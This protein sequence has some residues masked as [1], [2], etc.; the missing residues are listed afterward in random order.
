MYKRALGET[1]QFLYIWPLSTLRSTIGVNTIRPIKENFQWHFGG[2]AY[3]LSKQGFGG[4]TCTFFA[5]FSHKH[6]KVDRKIFVTSFKNICCRLCPGKACSCSRWRCR[7]TW[8]SPRGPPPR[9]WTFSRATRSWSSG[10][11]KVSANL[12]FVS[13]T[14]NFPDFFTWI[15]CVY[16]GN[17]SW[18]NHLWDSRFCQCFINLCD[19]HQEEI[20]RIPKHPHILEICSF[21]YI[22][23]WC[24]L[25]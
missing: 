16:A 15:L 21:L 20:L 12:R 9:P 4:D 8:A 14:I 22:W 7:G 18:R 17:Y 23:N 25:G 10:L 2:A 6:I 3:C 1:F 13:R 11:L 24:I 19:H 5:R